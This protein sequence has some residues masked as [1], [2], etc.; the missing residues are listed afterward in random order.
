VSEAPVERLD[1]HEFVISIAEDHLIWIDFS[2]GH[3]LFMHVRETRYYLMRHI[4]QLLL[5]ITLSINWLGVFPLG[6]FFLDP[7]FKGFIKRL[8]KTV[9]YGS[10]F[11]DTS[12][13]LHVQDFIGFI[14]VGSHIGLVDLKNIWMPQSPLPG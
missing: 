4:P 5:V 2:M 11:R 1:G 9:K 14:T 3:F 13:T 10:I 8:H 12:W 7:F 6:T